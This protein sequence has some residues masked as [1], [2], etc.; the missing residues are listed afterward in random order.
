MLKFLIAGVWGALMTGAGVFAGQVMMSQG[1]TAADGG[2]AKASEITQVSTEVTGAPIIAEGRVLGYLV[3]RIK[4]SVDVSKLPNAKFE[5]NPFLVD[6]AFHASYEI[7]Q[8]GFQGIGP[9]D[10]EDLTKKVAE[11]ANEKLG[12]GTVTDVVVDQFNYVPSDRVRQNIF[13][14]K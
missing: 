4:S 14:P 9:H 6:A 11:R 7:Y 12:A 10:L 5:V 13:S 1:G 2:K 3:F 8:N